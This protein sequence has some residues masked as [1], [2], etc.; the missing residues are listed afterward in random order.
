M[1]FLSWKTGE[2]CPA[3]E[4]RAAPRSPQLPSATRGEGP[5]LRQGSFSGREPVCT[6]QPLSL[7]GVEAVPAPQRL[8]AGP[9]A[10]CRLES[11]NKG[12]G[13]P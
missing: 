12:A 2:R 6:P 10:S 8:P 9:G 3:W 11:T 4:T 13:L 5:V 7:C 1:R